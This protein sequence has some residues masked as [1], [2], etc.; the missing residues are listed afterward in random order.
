MRKFV[1]PITLICI[2][3]GFF[4][5]FQLKIQ[6]KNTNFNAVSQKNNNLVT[7]I[8]DLENEI[9]NQESQIE[10][11]RNQLNDLQNENKKGTLHD[12]Q[13]EL[14]Q[15][16]IDAGLTTVA[17]KGIVISIDDNKEGM[18]AN[19]N[20]D[21]N[22]YI[23]HSVYI[24]NVVNDLKIGGAEAISINGQRLMTTSEICCVGN[25]ILINMTRIAPPFQITAIGSPKLLTESISRGQ[26]EDLKQ[27]NFPVYLEE[28]DEVVIPSYKGELQFKYATPQ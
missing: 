28:H 27:A 18:A 25:L 24:L 6:T 9:K 14:M 26:L 1:L 19:P 15:A 11:M 21:P 20:D 23:I 8:Q 22:K 17:G 5:A 3:S 10:A 13:Q 12:L 2:I 7:V 16:K 4:L